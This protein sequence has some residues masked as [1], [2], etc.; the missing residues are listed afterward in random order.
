MA[1]DLPVFSPR[2]SFVCN[3]LIAPYG[4]QSTPPSPFLSRKRVIV[5]DTSNEIAG[6]GDVAHAC[7]GRARR[8]MV[9][10]R[11]TQHSVMLEALQNHNPQVGRPHSSWAQGGGAHGSPASHLLL[12]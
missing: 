3:Y 6:D 8:M 9:N 5:V 11:D 10:G 7:I 1:Q 2:K 4:A 12:C